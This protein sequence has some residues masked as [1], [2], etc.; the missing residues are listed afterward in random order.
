[1]I[2]LMVSSIITLPAW[3]QLADQ[4]TVS[5]L[6]LNCGDDCE[7]HTFDIDTVLSTGGQ[8]LW[9]REFDC[10]HLLC[11]YPF[12]GFR[13]WFD[14]QLGQMPA[15]WVGSK[16]MS[17]GQHQCAIH[18]KAFWAHWRDLRMEVIMELMAVE[19]KKAGFL[20]SQVSGFLASIQIQCVSH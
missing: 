5:L 7:N 17:G 19:V 4:L 16:Y 9:L 13:S 18:C 14:W 6:A 3:D 12:C 2:I 8:Y 10:K 1:M 15:A 20:T 11:C